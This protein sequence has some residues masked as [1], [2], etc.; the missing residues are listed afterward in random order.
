MLEV[1]P[2]PTTLGFIPI[3]G[4]SRIG[5]RPGRQAKPA[6]G[7]V[8]CSDRSFGC[9]IIYTETS[10][11]AIL[12]IHTSIMLYT[13]GKPYLMIIASNDPEVHIKMQNSVLSSE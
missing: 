1:D 9:P 8:T 13:I 5:G 3:L 2:E 11:N 10:H 4:Q 6:I 7:V 12:F